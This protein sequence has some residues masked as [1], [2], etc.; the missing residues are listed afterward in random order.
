MVLAAVDG[1]SDDEGGKTATSEGHRKRVGKPLVFPRTGFKRKFSETKQ[2]DTADPVKLRRI[3]SGRC[4]C[5]CGC[6]KSFQGSI[7]LFDEFVKNRKHMAKMTKLE[8]DQHVIAWVWSFCFNLATR[9]LSYIH[10]LTK[11]IRYRSTWVST[12]RCLT[13]SKM[14]TKLQ[15]AEGRGISDSVASFCATGGIAN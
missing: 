8:K 4:G 11:K 6:F 3:V 12:P 1:L 9:N 10:V 15:P 5:L 7:H 2:N 13:P 14:R